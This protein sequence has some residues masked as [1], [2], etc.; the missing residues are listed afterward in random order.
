MINKITCRR[1][2]IS[3]KRLGSFWKPTTMIDFI[4]LAAQCAPDIHITTLAS[5]VQHESAAN[6][7]AIGVNSTIS[8]PR[9]PKNKT[10]AIETAK[11]LK[12]NGY[13]FDAGLGQIN[14]KNLEWLEMSIPDLFD[15]C[16]NL[17]ASAK[18]ISNCYK[19]ALTKYEKGEPALYA[20][21]SCYNSGNFS[22]GFSNGYVAKI[23]KNATV[24]VPAITVSL[25][26]DTPPLTSMP[27]PR[28]N[29]KKVSTK[30]EMEDVFHQKEKDIFSKT[31]INTL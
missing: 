9:Q 6:P 10:E 29:S 8:L 2:A 22:T 7:Y 14:I 4:D 25:S 19:K 12:A 17:Q 13:N 23:V 27:D 26:K 24:V 11:W 20:A 31:T 5:V 1:N 21:L 3:L 28:K 30:E 18:I 16:K 15:P